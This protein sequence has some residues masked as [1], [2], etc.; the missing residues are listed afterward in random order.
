MFI[1]KT[2]SLSRVATEARKKSI[3]TSANQDDP[4]FAQA[5]ETVLSTDAIEFVKTK[6]NAADDQNN[7]P[8]K[9]K[10]EPSSEGKNSGLD[11]TV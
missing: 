5:I 2:E 4:S 11:V 6:D 9:K 10:D 8:K 1:P 7:P 3:R